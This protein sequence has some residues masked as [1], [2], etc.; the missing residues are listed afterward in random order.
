MALVWAVVAALVTVPVG[1]GTV[2]EA[3]AASS[4][5]VPGPRVWVP[6]AEPG[7]GS[8][9]LA[10]SVTVAQTE[11]LQDQVIQV[12]WSG[13]TPTVKLD[14]TPATSAQP[15]DPTI[16]Y[17]V[18]IYQCRGVDPAP[19]DCYG[20]GLYGG[21]PALG[22]EQPFPGPGKSAPDLPTN[23]R[24]A[25]TGADGSGSAEIEVR[26]ARLSP[27]LGCDSRHRCSIVVEPNYGG[28]AVDMYQEHDGVADCDR[29]IYDIDGVFN[30]ASDFPIEGST[31]WKS[32]A[33]AGEQCAWKNRTVIPIDFT[34]TPDDCKMAQPDVA[35]AGL[36][37]A[38]R[39]MQQWITGLCLASSP[40]A[41]QYSSGGGEPQA[42]QG[43][44]RGSRID[45]ALTAL[46]DR[47]TPV[48]PYVYS[49]VANS[50][51][52]IGYL[53]DDASGRQ[54]RDMRLN[55]RLVAKM[56]TQSYKTAGLIVM[57][58]VEGNPSC[59]FTDEEFLS[60]N[61]LSAASGL[62]WPSC[63]GPEKSLPIVLGTSTD[64]TNQL[65]SW[66][67]N[68]PEAARFLEGERDPWGTRVNS[69][70]LRPDFPGFPI[71]QLIRQDDTGA[72]DKPGEEPLPDHLKHW[73]Q[74]EWNPLQTS[75]N[76]VLRHMQQGQV[77]AKHAVL[78]G[79]GN[80]SSL[81]AQPIGER[82]LFAVLDSAQAKAYA[83]PEA[84]LQN[85]AGTFVS[86][87][88]D[89]IQAAV[90]D[91]PLDVVTGTQQLPYGQSD[92]AYSRDQRAYPLAMV[93]YAMVPTG[94]LAAEKAV[95]VA[96]FLGTVADT[97]QMYG[98]EPGRLP[99]GFLALTKA[100]RAQAQDA[101]KH[102][103]AQ[104][105]TWP[106]NQKPPTKPGGGETPSTT[107]GTDGGT[108]S[109]GGTST[110]GTSTGGTS[111]GGTST[112]GTSG[113]GGSGSTGTTGTDTTPVTD[114][115]S[116]G[117]T[118]G[119][120]GSSGSSGTSGGTDTSGTSGGTGTSGTSGATGGVPAPAATAPAAAKPAASAAPTKN[121]AP[122]AA[123][124]VAAGSPSADRSGSA[125]LLLPIALIAGL[126][127]L[128]G[129]P[130]ALVL[131]GTPA[132]ARLTAATRGVWA[133]IR[134]S[135]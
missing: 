80:H 103:T 111:T 5:T 126:V 20:N 13:F 1:L 9:G 134:R 8:Y 85:A 99:E 104:D 10:G 59:I 7:T 71:D 86:P 40:L 16:L 122:L 113:T 100:Q 29:H 135:P 57:P 119:S 39:A 131:G 93:Q 92:T 90:A 6:G 67:A 11:N 58:S 110:G 127:L 101:V 12:S 130:A 49:P 43:F 34:A 98:V 33:Y 128:V 56:L 62:T 102:V 106:G 35:V 132:G 116:T 3:R 84:S 25:P 52:S 64:V 69:R 15:R 55:A 65:T 133:R 26:S 72:V 44:L 117:S 95:A 79:E 129:G 54:I 75:L 83:I 89:T 53:V 125:R 46:P 48:R 63:S 115:G 121:G 19:G 97:G 76:D 30:F 28:D 18:R 87:T 70:Y 61:R 41:V 123:A 14:G 31:N 50:G 109:T 21:D 32:Q 51:I 2:T 91:M 17:P 73:K 22:F 108:T 37:M 124:P 77:T 4:K 88:R 120:S 96:K 66:I 23:M 94:N 24:I 47:E 45:V 82:T 68:D 81:P 114:N 78:D 118:S 107:G 60:L 112:G 36:E 38:N 74:Y 42:R 105:G 27:S